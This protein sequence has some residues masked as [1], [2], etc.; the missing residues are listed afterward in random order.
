MKLFHFGTGQVTTLHELFTEQLRD[1][2]NAESQL[3]KALPE[4]EAAAH[5]PQLKKGLHDHWLQTRG[6]VSRLEKIFAAMNEDPEGK[7]CKA[8]QGLIREGREVISEDATPEVRDAALI[9]AAQRVEHYEMAGYGSVR[10]YASLMGHDDAE[11]LLQKTLDEE[12]AADQALTDA[13]ATLNLRV[14]LGHEKGAP[15]APAK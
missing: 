9:S 3:L 13:A 10:T 12:G 1:L 4:M 5:A 7:I 11:A 14:P 8:M 15:L 6:H 2:Y